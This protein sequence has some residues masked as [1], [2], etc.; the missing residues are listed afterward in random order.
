[1]SWKLGIRYE[2][3]PGDGAI[4]RFANA[5]RFGFDG[6]ELPGRYLDQFREDVLA[7]FDRLALPITSLSLG[8][9]GSLVSGDPQVRQTCAQDINGLLK[10]CKQLGAVGLVMPPIL[11]MDQIPRAS[12]SPGDTFRATHDRLLLEN[13]PSLAEQAAEQDVVL[14]LEPVNGFET[15][16]LT[17]VAHAA[18][19]CDTVGHAGLGIT[20]DFFHMQITELNRVQAIQRGRQWIR[21]VHVAENT[22]VEPGP[23][24]L[25][26]QPGFRALKE[27]E[28]EGAVVVECRQLSGP[29]DEVLPH[30]A[31]YLRQQ[32]ATA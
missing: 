28:Y 21:H 22:R 16:Y 14:M 13:L 7:N 8:F 6:V 19:L 12:V 5:E 11:H 32:I 17:T 15:D 26:F 9:R 30:S 2:V 29:P 31:R 18:D 4:E 24:E 10:F 23:G 27:I 3:L 25:S 20:I 1:M